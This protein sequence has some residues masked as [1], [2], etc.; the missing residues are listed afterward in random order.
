MDA[1][2]SKSARKLLANPEAVEA[3]HKLHH[4]RKDGWVSLNGEAYYVTRSLD[5]AMDLARTLKT[6][7]NGHK[8][9]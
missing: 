1:Y 8:K 3:L 9:A 5:E 7:T 2:I 4:N 6:R